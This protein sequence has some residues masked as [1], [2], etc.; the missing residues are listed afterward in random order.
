[1]RPT[2]GVSAMRSSRLPSRAPTS[3]ACTSSAF[4]FARNGSSGV[5]AKVVRDRSSTGAVARIC[6][7]SARAITRAAV[8][9][10]SPSTAYVRRYGGPKSPVKTRPELIPA[11]IGITPGRSITSR[12]RRSVC[13]SSR[14]VVEGAP[15]LSST[16]T[17]P[18]E[19]S[20]TL[21]GTS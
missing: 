16:F 12:T 5:V 10:A 13:S 14:P 8:L 20:V 1:M 19:T 2:N 17:L 3:E 21:N 11:R 4:P 15:A 7:A 6:P 9:I 18:F